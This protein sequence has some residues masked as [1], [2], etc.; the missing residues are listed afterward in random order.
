MNICILDD[1]SEK[2]ARITDLLVHSCGIPNEE[3]SVA[4]N[5]ASGRKALAETRF[6]LLILDLVVPRSLNG[7][8][9][10]GAGVDFLREIHEGK[11]LFK[12]RQVVGLTA[13][14]ELVNRETVTFTSFTWTLLY[15]GVDSKVW[16]D[17][18]K[19]KVEYCL[20]L[21]EEEANARTS[22]FDF[23]FAIVTALHSPEFLAVLNL[24]V[25]WKNRSCVGDYTEYFT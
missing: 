1:N 20:S 7:E 8:P 4:G 25:D 21:L 12:P 17:R 18:L 15:Y 5:L 10:Q 24:P 6:D 2:I 23:D 14:T 3:I 9:E 11:R 13:F 19:G 22:E 16:E